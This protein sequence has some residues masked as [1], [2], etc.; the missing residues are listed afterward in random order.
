MVAVFAVA[1][2]G[3]I[4]LV[5]NLAGAG[6]CSTTDGLRLRVAADPAIAPVL[7][8]VAVDWTDA[9]EPEVNGLC[10]AVEVTEAPT[11]DVA[12]QLA[13]AAGGAID[14]AAGQPTTSPGPDA[15]P[16]VWVPD[17]SYWVARVRSV[18]RSFF[19][20]ELPSLATS[21]IVLGVTDAG[22]AVVGEGPIEP[23]ALRQPLLAPLVNP[24]QP[25]PLPLLLSEPRRDTAGLVGAFW[26]QSAVVASDQDLPALVGIFRAQGEA[27]RDTAALLPAFQQGVAAAPMSEQAVVAHNAADVE[28]ELTA[29]PVAN[30]PV[31]D[32]PYAV[33]D[34]LPQTVQTAADM[35]LVAL[36][37]APEVFTEH[38]FRAPDGTAG[39]GFPTGHG[40]TADPVAPTPVQPPE[41][42]D[43][44][45]R[46]WT[47]ATS[48]ARVLSVVNVNASMQETMLMPDGTPVSKLQVFQQAAR[49]GLEMFTAGTDLGHW[50]YAVGL[51]GERDWI[52]GVPIE[53]LDDDHKQRILAA[54]DGLQTVPT[55]ESALFETLLAAYRAMKEGYDPS[56]S[57]T[58]VMWTDGGQSKS[59]GLTLQQTLRELERL[60]DLTRPIRVILLGLGP[61][62]DMA[63][64][65]ALAD[66]T[67]GAAF[68]IPDP[69]QIE[70]IFL[71]ALLA[72]PPEPV[73]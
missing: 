23:A 67:G 49:R 72:L 30:A 8:E 60:A 56:R 38:G 66:A 46:I 24:G 19:E 44:A 71:R 42:F 12:A 11:A 50:E 6:G 57:N 62:A 51:D 21:P 14:V 26:V 37:Q 4:L 17:S 10:V 2:A 48:D 16:H 47:S 55:N 22:K 65:Q 7:R 36:A 29:V 43:L 3:G 59:G 15:V 70:T 9:D 34:R 1:A 54:I 32:F 69:A 35:F 39:P 63:Q 20:P 58:L 31:L 27:P 53:L 18:S 45:R 41:R 28:V 52:E 64:L 40:V 33:V 5:Q 13:A 68:Q 73:T 25:P 61:G